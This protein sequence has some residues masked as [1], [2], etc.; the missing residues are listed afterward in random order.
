MVEPKKLGFVKT[1]RDWI[2]KILQRIPWPNINPSIVT[3]A[4]VIPAILAAINFGNY[5]WVWFYSVIMLAMD[6]IDGQIAKKH[7]RTSEFGY[8]MDNWFDRI[9]EVIVLFPFFF[10]SLINVWTILLITN[11][12]LTIYSFKSHN[13][14][15]IPLRQAYATYAFI[16]IFIA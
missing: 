14:F 11:L 12:I 13:H 6:L 7:H 2:D 3:V 16:L 8:A 5:F 9:T 4:A 10:I 1:S 15:I